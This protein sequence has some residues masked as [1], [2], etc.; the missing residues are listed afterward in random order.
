MKTKTLSYQRKINTYL[1]PLHFAAAL[2]NDD[3]SGL[4]DSEVQEICDWLKRI[5]PGYCVNVSDDCSFEIS[6]DLN[7][8]AQ[9][10]A[11]FDFIEL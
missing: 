9:D 7:S 2:I 11:H 10:C 8:L 4:E 3:E 1:L 6:N 5:K